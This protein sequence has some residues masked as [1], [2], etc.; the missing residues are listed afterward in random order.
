MQNPE[1]P[2]GPA[3]S[4]SPPPGGPVATIQPESPPKSGP[5]R[6]L[7]I[8]LL[9]LAAIGAWGGWQFLADRPFE[10][11]DDAFVEGHIV[12]IG[13]QVSALVLGVHFLENQRIKQGSLMVD[14]DPRD[15][16]AKLAEAKAKEES[17]QTRLAESVSQQSVAKA[18]VGQSE[19]E[20]EI[21]RANA[22]NSENDL[23]RNQSLNTGNVISK[24]EYDNAVAVARTTRAALQAAEKR[25]AASRAQEAEV[26]AQVETARA[27]IHEAQVQ[28]RQAE[29]QLS[30]TKIKAPSPGRIAR[31]SVEPGAY[32]QPGQSLF[33]I[34]T[35]DFWVVANFKETQLRDM[36]P[37]QPVQLRV[38][39]FGSEPLT[40]H[41]DSI[42]PGT[43]ARFSALPPEN[44]TGNYVKIVQRVPVKILIDEPLEKLERLAPGLS[45]VPRVK[46]R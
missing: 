22:E 24:R 14:L 4:K 9:L 43:G 21:A 32:A 1:A 6:P 30:Y 29:L 8:V 12:E 15:F 34:V 10:T 25:L 42:Q 38:D 20:V 33:S 44:A 27:A 16:E 18:T 17:A 31:K 36:R 2:A 45:V 19:A 26:Q 3:T 23:K 13:P 28:V 39:A 35:D 5:S 11:T 7:L 46:V 37:G 40:G 41:V